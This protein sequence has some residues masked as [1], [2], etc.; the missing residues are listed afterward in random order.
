MINDKE[1]VRILATLICETFVN[2][3]GSRLDFTGQ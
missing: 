1:I 3:V 2:G